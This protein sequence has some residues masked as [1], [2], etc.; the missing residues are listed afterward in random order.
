MIL[1]FC[2]E[3]GFAEQF[4]EFS[5]G[6]ML[7]KT[8]RTFEVSFFCESERRVFESWR[9]LVRRENKK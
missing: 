2:V 6:Y 7:G 9:E 1:D 4:Y 8:R 3:Q 5:S